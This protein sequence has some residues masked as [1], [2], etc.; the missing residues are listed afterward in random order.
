MMTLSIGELAKKADVTN[1]TLR[2]YEELGLITPKSRG[3]NRYRYYDE[4]HVLR[5]NTIKLL[6]QLGFGLK[7]IVAAL[8]P[9]LDPQGN[10]P[11]TG[12]ET[13]KM[14][15]AAL[16]DQRKKLIEKNQEIAEALKGI[17]TTMQNLTVCQGCTSS[18]NLNECGTCDE[19]P[20]EVVD[21]A[22]R[23]TGAA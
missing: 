2:Y 6:R 23:A 13:A 1:R 21:L 22:R 10:V 18:R 14:I 7:D 19:G 4:S 3:S 15:F 12:Q 17:E 20:S 9:V 11:E 16:A 8:N 5:L